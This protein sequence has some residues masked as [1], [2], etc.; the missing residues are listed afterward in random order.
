MMICI[1]CGLN[2]EGILQEGSLGVCESCRAKQFSRTVPPLFQKTKRELLP[3]DQLAEVLQ[4]KPGPKGL[5]LIGPSGSGK[6]R[7]MWELLKELGIPTTLV[8]S[9]TEF[10]HALTRE[11]RDGTSDEWIAAICR[12][13]LL[14]FD[15][16]GKLKMTER[17]EAELFHVVDYRCSWEL[18]IIATAQG[19]LAERLSEDRGGAIVRR[20]RDFCSI[21]NFR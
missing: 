4:W 7:C 9:G 12:T 6:T 13:P 2:G 10:G 8:F 20:L 19:E 1:M 21:V 15:D 17:A 16:L 18:P 11:Y 5:L 14:A 3:P